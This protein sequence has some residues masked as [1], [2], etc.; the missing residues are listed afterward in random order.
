MWWCLL[1]CP[2]ILWDVVCRTIGK[3]LLS[4]GTQ[5][6]ELPILRNLL[7]TFPNGILTLAEH[8]YVLEGRGPDQFVNYLCE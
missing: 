1:M 8:F 6:T 5:A 3:D 7:N 4:V 2:S